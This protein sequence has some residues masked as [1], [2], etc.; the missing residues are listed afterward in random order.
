MAWRASLADL[1]EEVV[2]VMSAVATVRWLGG[3][4]VYPGYILN[5]P[6]GDLSEQ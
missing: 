6:I 1:A 2:A 3:P 5:I 4:E